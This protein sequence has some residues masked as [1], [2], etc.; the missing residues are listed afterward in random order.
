MYL[1]QQ[2]ELIHWNFILESY[3]VTVFVPELQKITQRKLARL[4]GNCRKHKCIYFRASLEIIKPSVVTVLR[5]RVLF[6][7]RIRTSSSYLRVIFALG[8]KQCDSSE[9][10]MKLQGVIPSRAL[11]GSRAWLGVLAVSYCRALAALCRGITYPAG[12]WGHS[13][14]TLNLFLICQDLKDRNKK[15]FVLAALEDWHLNGS[16]HCLFS[17][18]GALLCSEHIV[19]WQS[20]LWAVHSFPEHLRAADSH[21]PLVWP[22]PRSASAAELGRLPWQLV[23]VQHSQ[24]VPGLTLLPSSPPDCWS[25]CPSLE[26]EHSITGGTFSSEEDSEDLWRCGGLSRE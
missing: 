23:A 14:S 2:W 4:N 15:H 13:A 19:V 25:S 20:L 3:L 7:Y 21:E 12:R 11:P 26:W 1:I 17:G 8:C 24:S 16:L 9:L 18:V 6:P 22:A 5:H 10:P